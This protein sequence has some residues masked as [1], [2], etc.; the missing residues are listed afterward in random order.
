MSIKRSILQPV[1]IFAAAS[2]LAGLLMGTSVILATARQNTAMK[3]ALEVSIEADQISNGIQSAERYAREVLNMTQLMP[4]SLVKT[5]LDTKIDN[6][7][8]NMHKLLNRPLSDELNNAVYDLLYSYSVWFKMVKVLLSLTPADTIPTPQALDRQVALINNQ[9]D[10]VA[11]LAAEHANAETERASQAIMQGLTI[12]MLGTIALMGMAIAYAYRKAAAIS[13]DVLK[14]S[15]RVVSLTS[16]DDTSADHI[17]DELGAVN[18]AIDQLQEALLEKRRIAINLRAE[19]VRAEAATETKSRFLAT[20]S[21]EIRTPINGVLGMAE[22]LNETGLTPEQR[23]YAETIQASSEALLRIVNDILDFSKLEAGK[24]QFL[25][26]PF[27]L[28]DVIFDVAILVAPIA[29]SKGVELYIDL[30]DDTPSHFVGD[31]GRIRQ[32]L[33]NIIGNAVKFTLDG[34]VGLVLRYD[35]SQKHPLTIAVNDT[36]VGIPEDQ[37]D[38]IFQAFEQ[39]ESTV[40]RRFEGT[41]LGLAITTRLI[42]AMEGELSVTSKLGVGSCFTVALN[43]PVTEGCDPERDALMQQVDQI[44]GKR[45]LVVCPLDAA[46]AIH[47]RLLGGWGLDVQ[48]H[49][50]PDSVINRIKSDC[51]DCILVD[52]PMEADTART[53]CHDVWAQAGSA[54][55][56]VLFCTE[57]SQVNTL[58]Q[59]K[60]HGPVHALMKPARGKYILRCLLDALSNHQPTAGLPDTS[61]KPAAVVEDFSQFNVLVAEDNRTNQLVLRKMLEPT[62]IQMTFC[63]DG[64]A[65]VDAARSGLFDLVLMDMSMPVMDGLQATRQIRQLEQDMEQPPCPIIALTANVMDT[66]EKACR[67]AGMVDFLTKPVRKKILMERIK[68]WAKPKAP[69]G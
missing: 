45:V 34:H 55:V 67:E 54:Q 56:P 1:L 28:R 15:S 50:T 65:A 27:A 14:I 23:S 17:G 48:I 37:I 61:T 43:L 12:G 57:S 25:E 36:G 20:M 16:S 63:G 4:T 41:G 39:V 66:D 62:G 42:S 64:Q 13:R 21:H 8:N 58:K 68:V 24:S 33:L 38:H 40:A 11:Q 29:D 6:V 52:T 69:A 49:Q 10:V 32:V 3:S 22:I 35:E 9:A 51:P 46:H 47:K 2:L 31:S 18:R 53:F 44:R 30:P 59:L 26:Q 5:Q 7:N 19:K 60:S